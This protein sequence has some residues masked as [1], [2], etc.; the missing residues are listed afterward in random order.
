MQP[1]IEL[2]GQYKDLGWALVAAFLV[3]SRHKGWW[4]DGPT[5]TATEDRCQK[6]EGKLEAYR[7]KIETQAE[8]NLDRIDTLTQIISED[9]K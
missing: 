5:H 3:Y 8:K 9:R 1:L 6:S 4:V 7:I 2:I